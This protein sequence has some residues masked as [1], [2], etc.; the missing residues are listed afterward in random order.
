MK[1]AFFSDRG[2]IKVAGENAANETAR[3]F[4]N[5]LFTCDMAL[6]R[7][8]VGIFGALLTPQGKIIADF[9]VTEIPQGH[10]GGFLLDCPRAAASTL[11]DK[12]NLYK[13]RAKITFEDISENFGVLAVWDSLNAPDLDLSSADPRTDRLGWRVLIP[14]ALAEKAAAFLGADLIDAANYD[15]HRISLR[16]PR[17]G[18]DFAYGGAFPHEANMDLL[19]GVSFTKGCYVGQEVVSRMEH[20]GNVRT[21][22][23]RVIGDGALPEPGITVEAGGK[24]GTKNIG[25]LGSSFRARDGR[26][27]GLAMLRIDRVADAR[28]QGLTLSAGNVP[29][30][31]HPDDDIMIPKD[32]ADQEPRA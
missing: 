24:N 13:L 15:E 4:L 31:I 14:E 27:W 28:T 17:G 21:R 3:T 22:I 10:G 18:V 19:N 5:G 26:R 29:I 11:R 23:L 12:L 8:G 1:A 9:I 2:I 25:T 32:A 20:R 6:V 16:V 7:P 30:R